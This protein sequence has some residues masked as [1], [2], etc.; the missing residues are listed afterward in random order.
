MPSKHLIIL[1]LWSNNIK[2]H[3]DK[4][5]VSFE[6]SQNMKGKHGAMQSCLD[7]LAL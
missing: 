3:S 4:K 1:H 6:D 5:K 7:R 2:P